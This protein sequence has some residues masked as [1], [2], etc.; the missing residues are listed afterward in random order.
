[1]IG[2]FVFPPE[3]TKIMEVILE[4]AYLMIYKEQVKFKANE[5]GTALKKCLIYLYCFFHTLSSSG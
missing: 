4:N 5:T 1:M 3:V 2:V